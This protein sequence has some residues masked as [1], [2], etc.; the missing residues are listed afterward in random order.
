MTTA[1]YALL[2]L[3]LWLVAGQVGNARDVRN[4]IRNINNKETE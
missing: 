1:V 3:A 4:W 2:S